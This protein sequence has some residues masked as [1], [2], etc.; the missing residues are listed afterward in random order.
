MNGNFDADL[1]IFFKVKKLRTD[2]L[3]I[4]KAESK[5]RD[6]ACESSAGNTVTKIEN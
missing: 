6:L 2:R 3:E 1:G 4:T 5:E